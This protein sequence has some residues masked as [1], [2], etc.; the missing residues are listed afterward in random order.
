MQVF[1][2]G[3]VFCLLKRLQ[4][5]SP[6]DTC[7][8]LTH[9]LSHLF[10]STLISAVSVPLCF[11]WLTII[12]LCAHFIRKLE[13][14]DDRTSWSFWKASFCIFRWAISSYKCQPN[15][16]FKKYKIK[17]DHLSHLLRHLD[18]RGTGFSDVPNSCLNVDPEEE[19]TVL[20]IA[21]FWFTLRF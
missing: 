19:K 11:A 14:E 6:I 2:D 9:T 7:C 12:M 21:L 10:F 8:L 17:A 15:K 16:S 1:E 5:R 18:Y 3:E 20:S 13:K 4:T